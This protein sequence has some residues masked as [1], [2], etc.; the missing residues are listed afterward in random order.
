MGVHLG[1]GGAVSTVVVA[2]LTVT[3]NG[4][5]ACHGHEEH[6]EHEEHK[7]KNTN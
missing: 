4:P 6:N 2:K 5:T 1:G 3:L 7:E